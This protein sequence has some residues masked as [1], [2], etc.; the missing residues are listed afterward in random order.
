MNKQLI[1]YAI[2]KLVCCCVWAQGVLLAVSCRNS[3]Q[4]STGNTIVS[5]YDKETKENG[6]GL[7]ITSFRAIPLEYTEGSML[8]SP[9]KVEIQDTAIIILDNNR[10][11]VYDM[12]GHFRRQIGCQGNGNGEYVNLA[13]FY[14]SGQNIILVDAFKSKLLKF[15]YDGKLVDFQEFKDAPFAN[16]RSLEVISDSTLFAAEYLYNDSHRLYSIFNLATGLNTEVEKTPM[17]T[18]NTK[19][20]V[21]R[22]PFTVKDNNVSYIKPFDK[23]IYNLEGEPVLTIQTEQRILTDTELSEIDD[24]SI[25]TYAILMEERT[26]LGFTDIFETDNHIFLACMNLNYTVIDKR[27]YTCTR[28][29]YDIPETSNALPLWNIVGSYGKTLIGYIS[30]ADVEFQLKDKVKNEQLSE[31][32]AASNTEKG[33]EGGYIVLYT[34]K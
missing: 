17:R 22:H 26:F 19:E 15:T 8:V 9:H 10:V 14:T 25:M 13:T 33:N 4:T 6:E 31:V 7:D 34:L 24:F 32:I 2:I 30:S 5:G 16:T 1:T 28:H 20:A 11:L 27:A 21:G 12:E 18:D 29:S 3:E 23:N